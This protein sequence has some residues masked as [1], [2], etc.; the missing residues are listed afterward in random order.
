M[1]AHV[2]VRPAT[3]GDVP[4][5]AAIWHEGWPD[6][7]AGHVP[8]ELGRHRT[9]PLLT[10]LVAERVRTTQVAVVDGRVVG[11]VTIRRDEV[12]EV[13]VARDARGRGV[14]TAL[15]EA[16][17]AAIAAH[18]D[19]AW[20]AVV[21]GNV[22]ARRS[23]ERHGWR[24]AGPFTYQADT[25]AGRFDVPAHRYVKALRRPGQSATDSRSRS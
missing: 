24:D 6:G 10:A 16:G 13:Y 20:L 21:A 2:T 3:D 12:E 1:T 8:A 19:E 23:Y 9:L 7:H 22:R 17:E 14:V 15:L 5:I 4:A 11:F 25:E 18:H